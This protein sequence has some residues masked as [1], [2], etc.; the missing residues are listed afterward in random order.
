MNYLMPQG[1]ATVATDHH[2]RMVQKHRADLEEIENARLAGLRAL[3]EELAGK[4]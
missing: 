3:A 1:L 2:K 4:A